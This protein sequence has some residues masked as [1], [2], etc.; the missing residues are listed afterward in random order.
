MTCVQIANAIFTD[1]PYPSF[2]ILNHR[3]RRTDGIILNIFTIITINAPI[4][5]DPYQTVFVF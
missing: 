2:P 4:R 3:H 5:A 1:I